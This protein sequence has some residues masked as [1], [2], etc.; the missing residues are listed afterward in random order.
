MWAYARQKVTIKKLFDE[1]CHAPMKDHSSPTDVN[2]GQLRNAVLRLG[3]NNIFITIFAIGL[4]FAASNSAL[5][6]PQNVKGKLEPKLP[7]V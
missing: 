6:K 3:E 1:I 2:I 7:S 5:R 4:K